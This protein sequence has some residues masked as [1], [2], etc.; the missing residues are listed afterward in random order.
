MISV[1]SSDNWHHLHG[2]VLWL[3]PSIEPSAPNNYIE[4]VAVHLPNILALDRCNDSIGNIVLLS[5]H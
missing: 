3:I 5:L 4:A 2:A 1:L